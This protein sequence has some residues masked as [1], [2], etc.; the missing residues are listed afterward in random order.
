MRLG[1]TKPTTPAGGAAVLAY[2]RHE[3]LEDEKPWHATALKTL[4]AAM[5]EM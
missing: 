3:M 5:L 2:L 4:T 1:K